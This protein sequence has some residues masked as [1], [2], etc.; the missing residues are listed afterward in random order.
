MDDVTHLL[1]KDKLT[2]TTTG[3][4]LQNKK[5]T[6][7]TSWDTLEEAERN[8]EHAKVYNKIH[9]ITQSGLTRKDIKVAQQ[10]PRPRMQN[11]PAKK[12]KVKTYNLP[13]SSTLEIG[14]LHQQTFDE[15]G[16]S[17]GLIKFATAMKKN[18]LPALSTFRIKRTPKG[19]FILGVS[20]KHNVT[21]FAIRRS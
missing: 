5:M 16:V 2:L 18:G 15:I 1:S 7:K 8:L 19:S 6:V 21:F 9:I 13:F 20:G 12:S 3:F 10:K 11:A 4:T 17:F 14:Q